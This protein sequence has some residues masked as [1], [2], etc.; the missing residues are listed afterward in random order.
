MNGNTFSN[1]SDNEVI[2]FQHIPKTAGTTLRYI[3]QYQYSP[4]AICEL[5]G[6]AGSHAERID[7]LKNLSKSEREKIKIIN[8]HLGFGLHEFLSQPYTY[9]TFLRDPV[10]RVISMYYYYQKTNNP[11]FQNLSLQEFVESYPAV[12][13]GMTKNFSGVTLKRQL[14][15]P[16]KKDTVPFSEE[17]LAIAKQ[18]LQNQFKFIGILERFDESAILLKRIL[19]WK[20]PLHDRSN[21]S[22]RANNIPQETMATIERLN[23]LDIELYEYAKLVFEETIAR[24]DSSFQQEV[25]QFKTANNSAFD[26]LYFKLK[27]SYNR[28]VHRIYKELVRS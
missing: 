24:Q 13:N 21:V 25:T 23:K 3:I 8:T 10:D 26:K 4:G 27:T 19:G 6:D 14:L 17:N 16:E 11:L 12:Q 1:T 15:P 7:K 18:N 5:Y 20:I 9:I 22:Q 28:G 2:I